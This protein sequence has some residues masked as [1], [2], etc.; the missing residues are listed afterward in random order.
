[1][2]SKYR[3]NG[4]GGEDNLYRHAAR[5]SARVLTDGSDE[6]ASTF[7]IVRDVTGIR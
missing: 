5:P 3:Q 4:F 2:L 1:M 6:T 7:K